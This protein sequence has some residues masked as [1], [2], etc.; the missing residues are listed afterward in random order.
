MESITVELVLNA[1]AH[2][3]PDNTL[4]S[5]T[6]FPPEQ[7]N[8]NGQW[9]NAISEIPYP[10]MCQKVAEGLSRFFVKKLSISSE[11]YYLELGPYQSITD[12]VEIK[13]TLIQ[14]RHNHNEKCLT[15]EGLEERKK[16]R[17]NYQE[18]DGVM[19][20]F[21][22]LGQIFGSNVGNEFGVILIGSGLHKPVFAYDIVRI[23]S[24]I[25]YTDLI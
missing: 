17:F 9:E 21:T 10:S 6:I 13:N 25:I 22:E 16:M 8:L 24:L 1:F 4:S 23:H 19:H 7:L 5:H 11:F 3:F 14:G 20:F 2:F 12:I 18:N 15:H